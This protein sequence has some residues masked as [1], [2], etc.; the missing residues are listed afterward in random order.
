MLCRQQF[1]L[2]LQPVLPSIQSVPALLRYRDLLENH[3]FHRIC[4]S[5]TTLNIL[6]QSKFPTYPPGKSCNESMS[7]EILLERYPMYWQA[8]M[9]QNYIIGLPSLLG[10]PCNITSII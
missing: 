5:E 4:I 6:K 7:V 8:V 3:M 9:T 10:N 2:I 1:G